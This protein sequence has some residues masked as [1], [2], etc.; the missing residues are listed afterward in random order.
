MNIIVTGTLGYD[1]ITVHNG[2][3]ADRIMPD[4]IHQISLSFL[5][6]TISDHFGGTAGNIAY[7]LKLLH[8]DP[9]IVSVAGHDFDR[10][11]KHLQNVGISREKITI[12]KNKRTGHYHVIN[13]LD[14]NQIGSF[15]IGASSFADTLILP[16]PKNREENFVVIAPTVPEA[17][18]KYVDKCRQEKWRYLFDPAFQTGSFSGAEL[19]KYI[20][21]AEILVGNDYEIALIEEKTKWSHQELI[22]ST[23][24]TITTLGGKG[25]RIETKKEAI[26]IPPAKPKKVVDPTGAGDCFR[27]GF[28]AGYL[29]GFDLQ[30]CGQMGSVAAVYTV[31][32]MGTQTHEFT[33]DEFKKRYEENFETPLTL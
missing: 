15:E 27:A 13:D 8:T 33:I 20:D 19:K 10:Y 32:K 26:E 31:E 25:A 5:V 22:Q 18:K 11:A 29:R 17:M 14:N 24:I 3:I 4:K 23:A 2:R 1:T 7:T 12:I 21:G 30:I 28:L 6:D 16:H 9:L